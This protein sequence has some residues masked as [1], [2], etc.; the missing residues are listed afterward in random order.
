MHNTTF[1][2]ITSNGLEEHII[3]DHI[4]LLNKFNIQKS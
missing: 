1:A 2:R 4:T 3:K